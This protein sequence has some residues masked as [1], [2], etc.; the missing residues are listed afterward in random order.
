MSKTAELCFLQHPLQ[1][2][3]AVL[4]SDSTDCKGVLVVEAFHID[5]GVIPDNGHIAG[6]R[7]RGFVIPCPHIPRLA[8]LLDD[9]RD[10][11]WPVVV[12]WFTVF[13]VYAYYITTY[14]SHTVARA[15]GY[16]PTCAPLPSAQ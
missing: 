16:S 3:C 11:N 1:C 5:G 9:W 8:D 14:K 12:A 2:L 10:K 15:P 4:A 7:Q 6:C 13:P